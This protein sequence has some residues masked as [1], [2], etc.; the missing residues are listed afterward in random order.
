MS[1][2]ESEVK[3]S[4]PVSCI[5]LDSGLVFPTGIKRAW[6]SLFPL[7][8]LVQTALLPSKQAM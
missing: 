7:T 1:A 3:P 6:K 8:F 2:S 4:V 5:N